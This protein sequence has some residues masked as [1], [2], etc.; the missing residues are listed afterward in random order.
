MN[1]K[2]IG[3]A[4]FLENNCNRTRVSAPSGTPLPSIGMAQRIISQ[5]S[6][7]PRSS[8]SGP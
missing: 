5:I 8:A 7:A 2:K 3:A 1:S 6:A 4:T